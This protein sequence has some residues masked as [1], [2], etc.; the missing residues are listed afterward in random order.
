METDLKLHARFLASPS[1][2]R[3]A[4]LPSSQLLLRPHSYHVTLESWFPQSEPGLLTFAVHTCPPC[5]FHKSGFFSGGW[6]PAWESA[7]SLT[8]VEAAAV[9]L[10]A[11]STVGHR[12]KTTEY[13]VQSMR[14][15]LYICQRVKDTDSNS[16][17]QNMAGDTSQQPS[18]PVVKKPHVNGA[19]VYLFNSEGHRFNKLES[20]Y[21]WGYIKDIFHWQGVYK[22][23]TL[24]EEKK[25]YVCLFVIYVWMDELSL[26]LS[27]DVGLGL[28]C[29]IN[30]HWWIH[31]FNP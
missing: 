7:F 5:I 19:A 27:I 26:Q 25:A 12:T 1:I 13:C 30:K 14:L 11:A 8:L 28:G 15:L 10:G 3:V 24:Q 20:E 4:T 18:G 16:P 22:G 29:S 9:D 31:H 23:Q 17:N 6:V 21:G 2:R